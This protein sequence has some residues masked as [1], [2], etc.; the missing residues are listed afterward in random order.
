MKTEGI[1]RVVIVVRDLD[2]AARRY[3]DLLGMDFTDFGAQEAFGVRAVVNSD[4]TVEIIS[5]IDPNSFAE[6][7]LEKHGEGVIGVAFMV[8]DLAE[9]RDKAEATG[10][11]VLNEVDFGSVDIWESFKEVMLNG[12]ETNGVP[13]ILVQAER[14]S[15]G[16]KSN[17]DR[18]GLPAGAA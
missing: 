15:K 7:Y 16:Q 5:P 17:P 12:G 10:V 8:Q 4:W 2:A 11:R 14:K 6:R 18:P 9:A 13:L 1:Q 3:S